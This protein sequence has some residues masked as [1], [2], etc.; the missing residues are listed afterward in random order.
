MFNDHCVGR[1]LML[2]ILL[3]Q[4]TVIAP[5]PSFPR[6][7]CPDPFLLLYAGARAAPSSYRSRP[8]VLVPIPTSD[9]P[10]LLLNST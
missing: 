5:S 2:S 9:T 3:A 4:G 10:A 8:Q 7:W 6:S 1:D